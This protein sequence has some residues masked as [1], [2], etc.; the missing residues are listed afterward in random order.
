[1]IL[2]GISILTLEYVNYIRHWGLRR[3]AADRKF[4]IEHAWNT[5]AR[6]SRWSLIELTRHS[7]HHLRASVPFW[8]LRPYEGTPQLRWGYY[9][10]WWP[11]VISPV[12]KRAM[13]SR[14]PDNQLEGASA[15]RNS[16]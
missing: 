9:A 5:E 3:P 8:K 10:S 4:Q 12:W 11:C 7:D 13:W 2:S 6:W 1:V 15:Q 16:Q 14:L